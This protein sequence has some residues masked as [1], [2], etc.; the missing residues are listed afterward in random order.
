MSI[1]IFGGTGELGRRAIAALLLAGVDPSEIR[2][3]GRNAE[4]LAALRVLGVTAVHV[5]LNSASDVA[6]AIK[7]GDTVV[8]ISGADENRLEQHL[9]VVEAAKAAGAE[10]ILYTS[11]VR[12]DDERFPLVSDHRSTEIAVSESGVPFMILRNG[13]YIENYSRN[14]MAAAESG[15]FVSATGE[16]R[17]AAASRQDYADALAA[18][19]LDE[20]MINR[21]L[22]LTGDT[23]FSYPDLA[24]AMAKIAG[25]EI[26][27]VAVSEDE[28]RER[29]T[30]DGFPG[31]VAAFIAANDASI[32]W[33]FLERTGDDL[34]RLIG[35]PTADLVTALR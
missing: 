34:T 1:V 11:V 30:R 15:Q 32:A 13:W 28:L 29:L 10:R 27:H 3:A 19:A 17:V 16:G 12:A 31:E 35:R 9:R 26:R 33:G 18:V 24:I 14:V 7:S 8:L 2:A 5:E 23:D 4:R 25:T 21:T 20:T 6:S 22:S